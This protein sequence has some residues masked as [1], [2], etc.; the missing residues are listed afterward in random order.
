M[1]TDRVEN[2]VERNG[3]KQSAKFSMKMGP[4]AFQLMFQGLYS[5]PVKAII[6]ELL[7]N[8]VDSHKAAGIPDV[9]VE[10]RLPDKLDEMFC[11]RDFGTGMSHDFIMERYNS[12]LDST[13]DDSNDSIGGFGLGGKTPFVYVDQFNLR[14]FKNGK[15]R[16]YTAV[17]GEDGWPEIN[18]MA[19]ID[20]DEPDGVEVSFPVKPQDNDTFFEAALSVAAT[21]PVRPV[22]KGYYA[23]GFKERLEAID[24]HCYKITPH[25][26]YVNTFCMPNGI[27]AVMGGISYPI[28][29]T[30]IAR[31]EALSVTSQGLIPF[32]IGELDV[33]P[34]RESLLLNEKT[35]N[36]LNKKLEQVNKEIIEYAESNSKSI[37]V[38]DR[39]SGQHHD[40]GRYLSTLYLNR[41]SAALK[42]RH[43]N[44]NIDSCGV[45]NAV[46][47]VMLRYKMSLFT[48]NIADEDSVNAIGVN[49][50]DA[51]I[52]VNV[53]SSLGTFVPDK[54]AFLYTSKKLQKKQI[55]SVIARYACENKMPISNIYVV[56][57]ADKRKVSIL[58][59]AQGKP[60]CHYI[61]MDAENIDMS[62]ASF[63][64]VPIL[65]C[66]VARTRSGMRWK[67]ANSTF[68][69][70]TSRTVVVIP[71]QDGDCTVLGSVQQH[72][73]LIKL[74]KNI[75]HYEGKSGQEANAYVIVN[76]EL[77]DSFKKSVKSA[78]MIDDYLNDI[79]SQ[80]SKKQWKQALYAN[81]EH[82]R[83][84]ESDFVFLTQN[85]SRAWFR[86]RVTPRAYGYFM[87]ILKAKGITG[88]HHNLVGFYRSLFKILKGNMGKLK[89]P[90]VEG[91]ETK[92][93]LKAKTFYEMLSANNPL[94]YHFL[95]RNIGY[96]HCSADEHYSNPMTYL[97]PYLNEKFK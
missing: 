16:L 2:V 71:E 24:E 44:E 33:T 75:N 77:V 36:A 58:W 82:F 1:I 56:C 28:P 17:T 30:D 91:F 12:A 59:H 5:Y 13:K 43:Y 34:S 60:K 73:T 80:M 97:I 20:T 48:A 40:L 32:E 64:G 94:L 39:V 95:R 35:K 76:R 23:K 57:G 26:T 42:R 79:M 9:P 66:A 38:A 68:L 7:A 93:S 54:T 84:F 53:F 69:S 89:I 52:F 72:E 50:N 18:L 11:V 14:C 8:G 87:S 21:M 65:F 90:E 27:F 49:V 29:G 88:R 70:R 55:A 3:T 61:D 45:A 85:I 25:F 86:A 81:D 62:D 10:M 78:V 22:C 41:V 63:R 37:T 47:K 46:R 96:S 92:R 4:K 74:A 19:E 83:Q 31:F 6:R 51:P 67:K 15:A